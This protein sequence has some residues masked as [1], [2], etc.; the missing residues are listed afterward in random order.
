MKIL[1]CNT[2]R[3]SGLYVR[4]LVSGWGIWLPQPRERATL[5]LGSVSS[6]PTLGLALS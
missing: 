5:D 3:F 1:I 4:I 6:S 2:I